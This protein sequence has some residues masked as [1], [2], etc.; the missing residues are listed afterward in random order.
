MNREQP[1]LIEIRLGQIE[2]PREPAKRYGHLQADH[3]RTTRIPVCNQDELYLQACLSPMIV[4]G[5]TSKA[6]DQQRYI[7][8]AGFRT[9]AM[10]HDFMDANPMH[11]TQDRPLPA[12]LFPKPSREQLKQLPFFETFLSPFTSQLSKED[13]AQL[14]WAQQDE[15]QPEKNAA[16]KGAVAEI[17]GSQNRFLKYAQLTRT[18][19]SRK[20]KLI[21][22]QSLE[23]SVISSEHQGLTMDDAT[24]NLYAAR[25][26]R[27]DE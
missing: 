26:L 3:Q 4:T 16:K 5:A 7:F 23:T 9:L 2:A 25:D 22:P 21:K 17:Y 10:W 18:T 1:R 27:I 19:L 11:K 6:S 20:K 15:S 12:I 24:A 14:Y 8:I 13:F